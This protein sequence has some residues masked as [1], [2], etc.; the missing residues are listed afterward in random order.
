M[1]KSKVDYSLYLVTDSTEAILGDKDLYHVVDNA[2][3]GGVTVVQYRDKTSSA[4]G[5]IETAKRLQLLCARHRVPLIINDRVD[6]ALAVECAGVHLGQDDMDVSTARHLLGP[7]KIIGATVSSVSEAFAAVKAGADYLGIGTL[8]ATNTKKDTKSIVGIKGIR[9]ILHHLGAR[10]DEKSREIKT[11]CIGGIHKANCQLV[12]YQLFAPSIPTSIPTKGIDGVAVVS[13]IMASPDPSLAAQGFKSALSSPPAFVPISVPTLPFPYL[14]DGALSK[15]H[16]SS[17]RTFLLQA[18]QAVVDIHPISH[19]MTNL[20]VQNFS[21][22]VA[23]SVGGSPIMS[24]NGDE[25]TDLARLSGGLVINMGT[26]T[27]EAL[28]NHRKAITAYN[29][30]GNPVI[31]DPV[32]AGATQTRKDALAYLLASGY[33]SLIKGNEPEIMQIAVS[34]GLVLR[35]DKGSQQ[36][37]G[38]DSGASHLSLQQ[39]AALVAALA[40]REQNLFLMTGPVDVL[41]NGVTTLCI[42]NGHRL[43]G[44]ITGSGCALGTVLSIYLAAARRTRSDAFT[45]AVA[46]IVHYNIAGEMAARKGGVDGPGTFVP[47]FMDALN[48]Y[49][50]TVAEGDEK[51]MEELLND[52]KI[53]VIQAERG[54]KG[55]VSEA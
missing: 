18:T 51:H 22:N 35:L 8:Y 44:A 50:T 49:S 32:G 6:V 24:N 23:L 10:G 40:R 12:R 2:I 42:S 48:L 55:L 14:P 16:A 37:Q 5:L 36:Q 19:N 30:V 3:S 52:M 33:F 9:Q 34:S 17:L 38:V 43:M 54:E 47:A 29:D 28:S 4:G 27:P 1:D 11:V 25:A 45:S 20:V 13:A 53:E 26:S 31:L 7:G 41:S 21:A 15:S 39:K 46:G